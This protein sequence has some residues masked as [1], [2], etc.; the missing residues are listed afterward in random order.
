VEDR[1]PTRDARQSAARRWCSVV[2]ARTRTPRAIAVAARW[3]DKGRATRG[4]LSERSRGMLMNIGIA[5]YERH[6]KRH[7]EWW[8]YCS[9]AAREHGLP[10]WLLGSEQR[11]V[12]LAGARRYTRVGSWQKSRIAFTR[13]QTIDR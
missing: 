6:Y 9:R 7:G 2:G 12:V 4:F 10:L 5:N 3:D 1:R 11:A 13:L 8:T